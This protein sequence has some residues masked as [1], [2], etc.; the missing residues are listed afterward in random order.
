MDRI[1]DSGAKWAVNSISL[2]YLSKIALRGTSKG[3]WRNS[4]C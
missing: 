4:F 2:F 3:V 1:S